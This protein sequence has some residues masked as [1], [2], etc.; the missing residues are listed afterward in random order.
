M[1]RNSPVIS[2]HQQAV[3]NRFAETDAA[4]PCGI[5]QLLIF[6]PPLLKQ[7]TT[8]LFIFQGI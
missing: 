4:V 1:Q 5:C 3:I 7:I 8:A 2:P 6:I